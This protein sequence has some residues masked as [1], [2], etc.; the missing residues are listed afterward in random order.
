MAA[1]GAGESEVLAAGLALSVLSESDY[2]RVILMI[3]GGFYT[4]LL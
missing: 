2:L 4:L 1:T 3:L